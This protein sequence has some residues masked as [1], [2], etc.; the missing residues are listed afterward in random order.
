MFLYFL[1][2]A[3]C[4]CNFCKPIPHA[5]FGKLGL[6]GFLAVVIIGVSILMIIGILV[7]RANRLTVMHIPFAE[8]HL[9]DESEVLGEGVHGKVL[10]GEYRGTQVAVKRMMAPQHSRSARQ[11]ISDKSLSKSCLLHCYTVCIK[12]HS[13]RYMLV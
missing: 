6:A 3:S 13:A 8:L 5:L 9:S 10:R 11:K 7:M 2:N 12:A 1:Q 4:I